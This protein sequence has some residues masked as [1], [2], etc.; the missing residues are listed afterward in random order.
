MLPDTTEIAQNG[1]QRA[2]FVS[3]PVPLIRQAARLPG[4]AESSTA[5]TG[6]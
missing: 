4:A 3:A 2:W 5:L 1:R 6:L